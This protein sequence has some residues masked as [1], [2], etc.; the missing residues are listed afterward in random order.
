MRKNHTTEQ[1][2]L[3]IMDNMYLQRMMIMHSINE[4]M[5]DIMIRWMITMFVKNI[6]RI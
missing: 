1:K 5:K 3:T 2:Y 4:N 6:N